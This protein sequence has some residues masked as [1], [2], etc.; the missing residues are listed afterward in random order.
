MHEK[1]IAFGEFYHFLLGVN[2]MK[3][4]LLQEKNHFALTRREE[5]TNLIKQLPYDLTGA[6]LR[7]IEEITQD[8][9]GD[10]MMSRLLQGDVRFRKNYR[11]LSFNVSGCI[12]SLS[13]RSYGTN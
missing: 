7:T 13:K 12:M 10:H 3:K 1:T 2:Q 5:V 9:T 6:Q 11:C 8:M 4:R